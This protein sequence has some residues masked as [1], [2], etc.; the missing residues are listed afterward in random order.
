MVLLPGTLSR[1]GPLS[2][3]VLD[4]QVVEHGSDSCVVTAVGEIDALTAPEPAAFPTAQLICALAAVVN[5]DGVRFLPAAGLRVGRLRNGHWR[6]PDAG[7]LHVYRQR[8]AQHRATAMAAR[9]PPHEVM[10]TS[11][12]RNRRSSHIDRLRVRCQAGCVIGG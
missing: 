9:I 10:N 2:T 11:T 7:A 4:L 6:P 8:A 3:D 5:L 1:A 12:S